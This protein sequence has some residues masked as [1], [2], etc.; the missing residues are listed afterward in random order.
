ML[1]C[2]R[3]LTR[4]SWRFFPSEWE[5]CINDSVIVV[6]NVA[7]SVGKLC[8]GLQRTFLSHKVCL[9]RCCWDFWHPLWP[10][11]SLVEPIVWL[12]PWIR[13][14]FSR[15]FA[16]WGRKKM[17]SWVKILSLLMSGDYGTVGR[18]FDTDASDLGGDLFVWLI[19][20]QTNSPLRYKCCKNIFSTGR[21][22]RTTFSWNTC[23]AASMFVFLNSD[24]N[25]S[26]C[27]TKRFP[28]CQ[29][30]NCGWSRKLLGQF[31][32]PLR[33]HTDSEH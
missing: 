19:K 10:P 16:R 22:W 12:S 8:Q 31:N 15:S 5:Q 32:P 17:I 6:S 9:S 33:R 20:M 2:S 29:I 4:F 23:V 24:F 28:W 25:P 21:T 1:S 13:V 27:P 11:L 3:V 18:V 7:L 14:L 30:G 26:F